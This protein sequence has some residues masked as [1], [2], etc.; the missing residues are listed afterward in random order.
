MVNHIP[1]GW[2]PARRR[3]T[4]V[5]A[6]V[7]ILLLWPWVYIITCTAYTYLYWMFPTLKA[8]VYVDTVD[9]GELHVPAIIHQTW[10][11]KEIPEKWR[12]AQKSCI[13]L[14]P[15]YEYRLWTDEDGLELIKVR[16]QSLFQ[17]GFGSVKFN[18]PNCCER[19]LWMWNLRIRC[20][21]T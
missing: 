13:E 6:L 5:A 19:A 11:S 2:T 14:H 21:K 9:S 7:T 4:S 10:K 17:G 1:S 20:I 15:E 18:S 8:N 16:S 3:L 12:E